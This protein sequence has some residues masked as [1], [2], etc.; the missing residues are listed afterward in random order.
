M[1]PERREWE[2]AL[3]RRNGRFVEEQ[4]VEDEEERGSSARG[5]VFGVLAGLLFWIL[6]GLVFLWPK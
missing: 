1:D 4:Y 3:A 6:V 2:R 5:C